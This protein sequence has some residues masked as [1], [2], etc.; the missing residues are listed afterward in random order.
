L[1]EDCS[2]KCIEGGFVRMGLLVLI[3][4]IWKIVK[5]KKSTWR[6]RGV[7]VIPSTSSISFWMILVSLVV[8]FVG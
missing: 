4:E 1:H 3:W 7:Y 5:K 8:F 6:L 2:M